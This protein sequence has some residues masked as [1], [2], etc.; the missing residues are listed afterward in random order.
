MVISFFQG[1][2]QA[3]SRY[4]NQKLPIL[5]HLNYL[6]K[7][8][9]QNS[10]IPNQCLLSLPVFT[11]CFLTVLMLD[12]FIPNMK[13][14][15]FTCKLCKQLNIC[16]FQTLKTRENVFLFISL[17]FVL[18]LYTELN[19]RTFKLRQSTQTTFWLFN[20]PTR[21]LPPVTVSQECYCSSLCH[22]FLIILLDA[23]LI[24]LNLEASKYLLQ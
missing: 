16:T 2:I 12:H 5:L 22:T 23:A 17:L 20:G 15:Y 7:I 24:S 9:L 1:S 6:K 18:Q 10:F 14:F 11:S 13:T 3:L 19:F 21:I 8:R 4:L